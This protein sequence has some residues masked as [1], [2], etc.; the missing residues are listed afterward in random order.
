MK[1]LMEYYFKYMRAITS[2]GKKWRVYDS[3]ILET[4]KPFNFGPC[5]L[6]TALK[7]LRIT[8]Y[9]TIQRMTSR[10]KRFFSIEPIFND[11]A[12]DPANRVYLKG[13]FGIAGI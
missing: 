2:D 11:Y 12:I 6:K 3:H 5:A 7:K 9:I 4:L 8:G 10:Y 1:L 13:S